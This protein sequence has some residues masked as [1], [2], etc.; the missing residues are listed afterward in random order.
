[1]EPQFTDRGAIRNKQDK[2]INI[3]YLY[4]CPSIIAF[5]D[6]TNLH[7]SKLFNKLFQYK[8]SERAEE[9]VMG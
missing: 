1:M 3:K 6:I 7:L 2:I 5:N 4:C 9:E 8:T